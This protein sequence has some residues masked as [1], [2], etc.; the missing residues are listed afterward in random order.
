MIKKIYTH[1]G[2][3]DG[4]VAAAI[5]C[6][7]FDL[8]AD[9]VVE[10]FHNSV[11]TAEDFQ[12]DHVFVDISPQPQH[13]EFIRP[14]NCPIVLDHHKTALGFFQGVN[15]NPLSSY[16]DVLGVSGTTLAF[17]FAL[18][19]APKEKLGAVDTDDVKMLVRAVGARDTFDKSDLECFRHGS[20]LGEYIRMMG[21][22]M[23]SAEF[24]SNFRYNE[25]LISAGIL[26]ENHEEYIQDIYHKSNYMLVES[27][28]KRIAI[29]DSTSITSDFTE[30]FRKE[31]DYIV[32]FKYRIQ[33]GELSLVVSMR[34]SEGDCVRKA[35]EHFGGGGQDKAAG[36]TLTSNTPITMV[37]EQICAALTKQSK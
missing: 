31:F 12:K 33:N 17:S 28:G 9:D 35:A 7:A 27:N 23:Y 18:Q 19:N 8:C 14:E 26:R 15:T 34:G 37:L 30:S 2:C 1:A 13:F 16:S 29:L 4:I 5:L 22:R 11:L 25:A 21:R 6:G 32:G 24:M 20:I 3:S 36:F 10:I